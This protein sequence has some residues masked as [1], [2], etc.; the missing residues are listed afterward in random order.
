MN[1]PKRILVY[2]F[3][4]YRKFRENITA[5]IVNSLAPQAGLKRAVFRVRFH[6]GQF[7]EALKRHKPDFVLG[8]GQSARR[9]IE[10]E[11]R[12]ANRRRA[13]PKVRARAI[14]KRG[15][16]WLPAT[17]EMKLGASV[18]RSTNAG[19]YVCNFS[20]YVMLDQIRRAEARTQL[21]FIHIPHDFAPREAARLVAVA[22]K[23]LGEGSGIL[24]CTRS[25]A[26]SKARAP[27]RT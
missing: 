8:L 1:K 15:P 22:V 21:G 2:G 23:K 20:M 7:V 25:K 27:W 18:K 5:K 17:L 16:R 19:E 10:F 26:G 11:T 24:A 9:T 6:R 13:G 12:A 4:P 3:G 14:R